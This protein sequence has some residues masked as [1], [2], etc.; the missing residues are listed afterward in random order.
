MVSQ[1]TGY[2]A[3]MLGLGMEMEAELGIDSIKQVEI[4]SALKAR[5]PGAPEI[6]ASELAGLRTLQDVVDAVAAT[7]RVNP[8]NMSAQNRIRLSSPPA[9]VACAAPRPQLRA[10]PASGFAMAGLRDA[11]VL[12]TREDP[13]FADALERAMI[14]RGHQGAGRSTRCP[15]QAGAVIC[16]AAL[17]AASSPRTA[18]RCTCVHS[19]RRAAWPRAARRHG[20]SSPCSRRALGLQARICRSA[21]RASSRPPRGSGLTP[22]CG[23][24]NR[25][26]RCGTAHRRA[27]GGRQRHR[28]RLAR[29]WRA[30]GRR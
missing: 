14:A 4:L 29:R 12:I 20:F 18:L 17:A 6:P 25:K 16:L 2:P 11:E 3:D 15:D 10:V 7:H 19:A 21:W 8:P 28:G 9:S 22:R 27:A 23:R 5:L 26:P 30:A 1:K 13:V 24:S